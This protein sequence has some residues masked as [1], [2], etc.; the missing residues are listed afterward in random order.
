MTS[1]PS[2]PWG[3]SSPQP[4]DPWSV[5]PKS[6]P[7]A[8]YSAPQTPGVPDPAQQPTQP[9]PYTP[10]AQ[11]Q[12][13]TPPAESQPFPPAAESQSYPPTA[14][15]PSASMTPQP[16]APPAPDPGPVIV[17]IAEIS[18]TSTT[19]FTPTGDI[20]LAGSQWQVNDYWFS[21]QRIPRWAIVLAIVGFC[22][23]TI[24][25]LL[26]LLV[27]ETVMQGTV[28]VTVT[29]GTRQYVARIPVTDQAAVTGINQQVNY[30]R[31]LAAL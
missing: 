7:P 13:H 3:M 30:V 22:V 12:P 15:L 19:V 5:P 16:Y 14:P 26:F 31:T 2:D 4:D 6:T 21:Q 23:L 1:S 10:P 24:F 8:P 20:P 18:V 9:Q 25:S 27:K 11:P 29:N 28:Q 17:Q